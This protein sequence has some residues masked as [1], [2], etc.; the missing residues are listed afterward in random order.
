MRYP[1]FVSFHLNKI[2]YCGY[3]VQN[4]LYLIEK[5]KLEVRFSQKK[6]TL[7]MELQNRIDEYWETLIKNGNKYTRGEVFTMS[8]IEENEGNIIINV[9]LSDYAHYLFT[10]R[11]GLPDKDACKNIHTSCLIET[12]DNV[13]VFGRMGEQTSIPGNIQCAG[14]GLN[15]EDIRGNVIDLEH[16]IRKELLEEVGIDVDN[17]KL[18]GDFSIKYLRYDSN[19]H[20][21]AAIFILKL[22]ITSHDFAVFYDKFEAQ[23]RAKEELPEFKELVYLPKNKLAVNEFCEKEKKHLDHYMLPLLEEVIS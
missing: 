13:L 4:K 21:A 12:S 8:N 23:I 20:S 15:N 16:N 6:F 5:N 9:D 11:V 14:G 3:V 19:I 2:G 22:K 17:E 18:V 10:R 7:P 1:K